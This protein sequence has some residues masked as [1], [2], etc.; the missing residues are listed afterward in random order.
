M[1]TYFYY[2][3]MQNILKEKTYKII[4]SLILILI[5][6]QYLFQ[7]RPWAIDLFLGIGFK[8]ASIFFPAD[9]YTYWANAFSKDILSIHP[10]ILGPSLFG[11]VTFLNSDLSFL[12]CL[13]SLILA[14]SRMAK[15]IGSPIVYTLLI[16][17]INPII[18][19]QSFFLNKEIHMLIAGFFFV[20]Y[21]TKKKN[22]D[23]ALAIVFSLFTKVEFI[24]IIVLWI[25]LLFFR[26]KIRLLAIVSLVLAIT[27]LYKYIP[28]IETKHKLVIA[29]S[30][31]EGSNGLSLLLENLTYNYFLFPITSI[32]RVFNGAFTGIILFIKKPT[33]IFLS[34]HLFIS[35]IFMAHLSFKGLNSK[36]VFKS[37]ELL[38]ITIWLIVY[39]TV[40]YAVHR[41]LIPIYPFLYAIYLKN[42]VSHEIRD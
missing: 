35:G 24:G 40:P 42:K 23:L 17:L 36:K 33:N 22:S 13:F 5:F 39:A 1:Q 2:V 21:S 26:P 32:L 28:G 38:F 10:S 6:W 16:V 29:L 34:I 31:N 8:P 3:S 9:G 11:K 27:V 15:A 25:A 20:A 12:V 7:V 37:P 30:K 18:S 4:L 14:V 41:Y 19:M